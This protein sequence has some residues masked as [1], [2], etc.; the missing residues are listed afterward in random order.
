[1]LGALGSKAP[2]MADMALSLQVPGMGLKEKDGAHVPGMCQTSR[3]RYQGH[4][5]I[6]SSSYSLLWKEC[7]KIKH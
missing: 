1:M 4:H 3:F 5:Y 2:K 7:V 6:R